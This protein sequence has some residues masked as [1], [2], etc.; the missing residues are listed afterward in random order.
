MISML[1]LLITRSLMKRFITLLIAS[2][3][4]LHAETEDEFIVR[5]TAAWESKDPDKV[6]AL[7]GDPQKLDA[8]FVKSYRNEVILYKTL[9][10]KSAHIVPFIPPMI[11]TPQVAEGKIAF[12]PS[13]AEECVSIEFFNEEVKGSA[14]TNSPIIQDKDGKFSYATP[15]QRTFE[16]SGP[17]MSR[18]GVRMSHEGNNSPCPKIIAVVESCGY[19]TWKTFGGNFGGFRAHKIL[20]LIVP[21]TSEAKA[22]SFEIT[23]D[24]AEP[25]FKK[26]IDTSKGAIIPIESPKP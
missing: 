4:A 24:D 26:T 20:Q 17:K 15:E 14:W 6:L 5:V 25:F 11:A 18:F 13:S 2:S 1:P 22:I 3:F 16:W 12:L 7:Y 23:K 21:P 10:I 19:T 9:R 8:E